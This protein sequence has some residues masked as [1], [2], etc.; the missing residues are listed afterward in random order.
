MRNFRTDFLS[1]LPKRPGFAW[2]TKLGSTKA[3]ALPWFVRSWSV[4]GCGLRRL[5]G[6]P[7]GLIGRKVIESLAAGPV[8]GML[9]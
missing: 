2:R 9:G 3:R 4:G 5:G 6:S 7:N 1:D 8:V